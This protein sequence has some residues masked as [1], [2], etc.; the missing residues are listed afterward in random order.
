MSTPQ[1][2]HSAASTDTELTTLDTHDLWIQESEPKPCTLSALGA[3]GAE[4]LKLS[5][6]LEAASNS[7]NSTP[8]LGE[9]SPRNNY[10]LG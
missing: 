3:F 4:M 8:K 9:M 5:R 7:C 1:H 6:G 10:K 2:G